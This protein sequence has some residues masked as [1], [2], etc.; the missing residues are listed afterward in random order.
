VELY[1]DGR[2]SLRCGHLHRGALDLPYSNNK[3][4][5]A[6]SVKSVGG[7]KQASILLKKMEA[8]V[9]LVTLNASGTFLCPSPDLCLD[10]VL[11]C[12]STH[13]LVNLMEWFS[14]TTSLFLMNS[15]WTQVG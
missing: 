12:G 15:R 6:S 13:R 10:T 14:Y 3:L 8:A 2:P 1:T 9:L 5:V 4:R 7:S 11:S